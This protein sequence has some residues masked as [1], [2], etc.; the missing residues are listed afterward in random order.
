M[1]LSPRQMLDAPA[2][3]HRAQRTVHSRIRDGWDVEAAWS[4][5][6]GQKRGPKPRAVVV[7]TVRADVRFRDDVEAQRLVE[8]H[9]DGMTCEDVASA[10]GLSRERV[11]QIEH[12]A[13]RTLVARLVL[14]GIGA[15]EVAAGF[16]R[17]ADTQWFGRARGT[18]DARA[19]D[20]AEATCGAWSEQGQRVEAACAALDEAAGRLTATLV[21]V[22][23]GA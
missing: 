4:M 7:A 23:R 19:I 12:D 5:P 11:R 3:R 20:G 13:M 15:G 6:V 21:R 2:T 17:R 22:G 18:A 9:P 8:A 10:L 1:S 16:A 14:S